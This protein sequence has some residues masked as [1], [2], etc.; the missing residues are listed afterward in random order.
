M[1]QKSS[2]TPRL[3]QVLFIIGTLTFFVS[4]VAMNLYY[5]ILGLNGS[6]SGDYTS[7]YLFSLLWMFAP[8]VVWATV[9]FTRRD[10]KLS[11]TSLFQSLLLTFCAMIVMT[12]LGHVSSLFSAFLPSSTDQVTG[13]WWYTLLS[14]GLP[15]VIVVCGL[16]MV[17]LHLRRQKQW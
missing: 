11:V 15:L 17:I 2:S 8:V 16:V 14:I 1:K 4:E 6:I 9:H 12:A 3:L 5:Y 10:R 13:M 7:I